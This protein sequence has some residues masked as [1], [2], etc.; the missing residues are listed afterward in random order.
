MYTDYEDHEALLHLSNKLWWIYMRTRT[1]IFQWSYLE[2]VVAIEIYYFALDNHGCA[3]VDVVVF[4]KSL[5]LW[6][7]S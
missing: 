3:C 4:A 7:A 5:L 6:K 2:Y 1:K